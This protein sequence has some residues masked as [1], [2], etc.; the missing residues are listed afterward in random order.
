M[1]Y[2]FGFRIER[3]FFVYCLNVISAEGY[4]EPKFHNLFKQFFRWGAPTLS[5]TTLNLKTDSIL[6]VNL[7]KVSIMTLNLR[8][9]V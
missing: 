7:K 4:S 6:I 1:I 8:Q 3:D 5:I 9:S 2:N